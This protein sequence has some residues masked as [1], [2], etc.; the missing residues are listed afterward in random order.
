MTFYVFIANYSTFVFTCRYF[1]TSLK[2]TGKW[3]CKFIKMPNNRWTHWTQVQAT[4]VWIINNRKGGGDGK[5]YIYQSHTATHQDVI[6]GTK[7]GIWHNSVFS[8]TC[9]FQTLR[10]QKKIS[11]LRPVMWTSAHSLKYIQYR[12]IGTFRCEIHLV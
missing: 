7:L 5:H 8:I 6:M 1:T 12:I 10:C 4:V 3:C 2:W 11:L 9:W